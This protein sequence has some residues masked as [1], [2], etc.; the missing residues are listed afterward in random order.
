MDWPELWLV[1]GGKMDWPILE[2]VDGGKMDWPV[3]GLV[4]RGK[5][6]WPILG[7]VDGVVVVD[8][9]LL[10]DDLGLGAAAGH[11]AAE[12]DVDEQHD[13]KQ[14]AKCDAEVGQPIGVGWAYSNQDKYLIILLYRVFFKPFAC[15]LK[16]NLP[17]SM[18]KL[19]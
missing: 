6:D 13:A 3:L 12:E 14:D 17:R 18:Q 5:M 7:L 19:L 9:G 15:F 16:Y 1:D 10:L 11:G 4:D 2:L 8:A